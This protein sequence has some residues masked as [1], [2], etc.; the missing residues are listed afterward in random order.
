[1][2]TALAIAA[3]AAISRPLWAQELN[4][5]VN[6]QRPNIQ[7]VDVT[8]FNNMQKEITDY[9]NNNRWTDHQFEALEKIP[10]F[11][12]IVI[13]AMPAADRFEG[14]AQ[15]QARRYAYNSSY[16]TLTLN[17]NDRDFKINYVPFQTLQFSEN[18]YVNN[19]CS[20]LNFYAFVILGFDY[21]SYSLEGG[22]D[23][24]ERARNIVNLSN[25]NGE[26]GWAPMTGNRNRFWLIE[27]VLNNNYKNIHTI[28][29]R[30]HR[31]GLDKMAEDVNAGRSV[32]MECVVELEKLFNQNQ[33]LY[34]TRIFL[35]TKTDELINIFRR[36]PQ[37]DKARF[38]QIMTRIDA[39]SA[40]QYQQVLAE[41]ASSESGGRPPGG[42]SPMPR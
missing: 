11:I 14:T 13:T 3:V 38:V 25:A 17:F 9:M 24:F 40:S 8:V 35:D 29:Y 41:D 22:V 30:Y 28:L 16:E 27:N 6:I 2:K 26:P 37:A 12:N 15:V 4:C 31:E 7:G 36:A 18:S 32:I 39:A 20:I 23:F 1:M 42:G 34:F 5:R 21:D 19:L 33:N 10:C